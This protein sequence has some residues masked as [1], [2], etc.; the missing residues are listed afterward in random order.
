MCGALIDRGST[1]LLSFTREK[2]PKQKNKYEYATHKQ[3]DCSGKQ[4]T[5]VGN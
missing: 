1:R 2:N 5:F 4:N 3:P